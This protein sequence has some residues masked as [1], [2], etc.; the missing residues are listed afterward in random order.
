MTKPFSVTTQN[1]W[2]V[3]YAI[4]NRI[5]PNPAVH[6]Y[7]LIA[8]PCASQQDAQKEKTEIERLDGPVCVQ[9]HGPIAQLIPTSL[10]GS[11]D[12]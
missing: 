4:P 12:D 9:I 11:T 7:S 2:L 10:E 8:V 1:T 5:Y 3:V 6:H